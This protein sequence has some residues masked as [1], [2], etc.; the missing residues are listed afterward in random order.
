MTTSIHE[1][2]IFD[3][4]AEPETGPRCD[5]YEG[6]CTQI[7]TTER[8]C[9]FHFDACERPEWA[10]KQ[11]QYEARRRANAPPVIIDIETVPTEAALAQSYPKGERS[12]PANYKDPEKIAAWYERD[13]AQWQEERV[14]ECSLNARLGRVLCIGY[15]LPCSDGRVVSAFMAP[16]EEQEAAM[17]ADFWRMVGQQGGRIVTFNGRSFD[18]RFLVL[19]SLAHGIRPSVAPETVRAWFARYVVR[20]HCDI[21]DLLTNWDQRES[22]TLEEWCRFVGVAYENGHTGADIYELYRAAKFTEIA[23]KCQQDVKAT[24]ALYERVAT[25]FTEAA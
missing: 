8:L 7:A 2:N 5:W 13:Q 22:G 25:M 16:Q 3:D 11:R 4:V 15:S 12:H 18:L 24:Q 10:A 23:T 19:R 17:L 6:N 1:D 20:P 14:K 21:R 9:P